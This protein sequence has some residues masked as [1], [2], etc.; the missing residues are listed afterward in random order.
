MC[1]TF[2]FEDLCLLHLPGVVVLHVDFLAFLMLA[3]CSNFL[4]HLWFDPRIDHL[5]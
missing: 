4:L 1:G 5:L 3:F 2:R